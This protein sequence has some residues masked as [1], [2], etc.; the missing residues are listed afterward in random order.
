M[1]IIVTVILILLLV[2]WISKQAPAFLF[3]LIALIAVFLIIFIAG[4]LSERKDKK[5]KEL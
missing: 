5:N 3:Y 4:S 2:V 1:K